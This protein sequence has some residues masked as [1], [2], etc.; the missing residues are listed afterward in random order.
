MELSPPL[1]LCA[2]AEPMDHRKL[3]ILSSNARSEKTDVQIFL[4]FSCDHCSHAIVPAS[5]R[6][7]PRLRLHHYFP[8]RRSVILVDLNAVYGDDE[9]AAWTVV[10][11][12][13]NPTAVLAAAR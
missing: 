2:C 13:S 4:K 6:S 3:V 12:L 7:T 5:T 9:D 8:H 1:P 11:E 10:R